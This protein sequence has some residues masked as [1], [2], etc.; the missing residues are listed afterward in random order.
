MSGE[1]ASQATRRDARALLDTAIAAADAAAIFI[2]ERSGDRGALAW[3][4][5]SPADFVSEVDRGAEQRIREIVLDR[6]PSAR[7]VGE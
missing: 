3:I 1:N 2:R 4:E 5:K 7:V 6:H